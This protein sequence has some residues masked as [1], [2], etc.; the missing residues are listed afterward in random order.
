[1]LRDAV[2]QNNE[3]A[4]VNY[5]KTDYSSLFE[6]VPETT[7]VLA[8]ALATAGFLD[9]DEISDRF[10][11]AIQRAVEDFKKKSALPDPGTTLRV[12]DRIGIAGKIR[13]REDGGRK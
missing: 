13:P 4:I 6:G 8:Q 10:G 9:K 5:T 2:E 7:M 3:Q 1:M 12:I 11:P